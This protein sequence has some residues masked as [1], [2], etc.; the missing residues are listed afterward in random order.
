MGYGWFQ[1]EHFLRVR[2]GLSQLGPLPEIRLRGYRKLVAARIVYDWPVTLPR[3]RPMA[4]HST[5]TGLMLG[6]AVVGKGRRRIEFG[7]DGR[8]DPFRFDGFQVCSFALRL[9]AGHLFDLVLLYVKPSEVHHF[10]EQPNAMMAAVSHINYQRARVGPFGTAEIE[11]VCP[12]I[13]ME[14]REAAMP[15]LDH[16]LCAL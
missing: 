13:E 14:D 16:F 8:G 4:R 9:L 2:V 15:K 12:R 7:A 6:Q 1:M 3:S 5:G 11:R 10:R